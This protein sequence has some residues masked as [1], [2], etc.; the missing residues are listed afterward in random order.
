MR[1]AA[2]LALRVGS[3]LV[4]APLAIGVAYVGGWPF[5]VF[6]G[7]A[8][9][10]VLWEWATLVA[11]DDRRSVSIAG[12]ASIVLAI[13]LPIGLLAGYAGGRIDTLLM[14]LGD[15]AYALP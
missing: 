5:A 2:E 4:L 9:I 13:G 11:G 15:L 14:R 6:W 3:A 12:G 7:V 10:G 1:P 8:A